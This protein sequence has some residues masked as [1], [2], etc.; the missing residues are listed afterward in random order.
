MR[1]EDT[2]QEDKMIFLKLLKFRNVDYKL[3]FKNDIHQKDYTTIK[4]VYGVDIYCN[5]LDVVA[6]YDE[7]DFLL[8]EISYNIGKKYKQYKYIIHVRPI[9]LNKFYQFYSNNI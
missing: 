5:N 8:Y 6:N 9:N 2:R 3:S 1:L 4:R 7:S